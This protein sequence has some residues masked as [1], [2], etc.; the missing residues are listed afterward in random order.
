MPPG[1]NEGCSAKVSMDSETS[2][3]DPIYPEESE[4]QEN[5]MGYRGIA[6]KVL[7]S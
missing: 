6:K 4:A 3:Y 7:P 1:R 5:T 2:Q